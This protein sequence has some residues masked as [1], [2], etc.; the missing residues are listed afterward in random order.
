MPRTRGSR[1][2]RSP[3]SPLLPTRRFKTPVGK[4]ARSKISTSLAAVRGVIDEGLK[5]TV[6]P[7]TSAGAI[8]QAGIQTGKFQG[9]IRETT[10]S[11]W[12]SVYTK[13]FGSSDG[14]V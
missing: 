5:T 14:I 4:P 3:T 9:V 1:V 10:P 7:A 8:F 2:R 12:R 13:F 6:S 11:G